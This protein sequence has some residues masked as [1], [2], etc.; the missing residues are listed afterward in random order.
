MSK[1]QP[2]YAKILRKPPKRPRAKSQL[3]KLFRRS[4]TK[5]RPK[6]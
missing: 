4:T 1:R 5:G 2:R 6:L 3:A